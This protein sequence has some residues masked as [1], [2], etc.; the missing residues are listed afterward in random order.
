M[1]YDFEDKKQRTQYKNMLTII[2]S[3]SKL[4]SDNDKPYLAYR[5]HENCF[6]KYFDAENL[7]RHDCSADAMKD[8]IGVGLKTWINSDIQKVAEFNKLKH[9][10]DG[11]P[12][13][14]LVAKV[15]EFRN[16]RITTTMNMFD[17]NK[18]IYHVVIRNNKSMQIGECDFEK[19]DI[20]NIKLLK[21]TSKKN[22]V[23]FT[24][25]KHT[26]NFN[27]SKSTLYMKFDDLDILDT[28]DVNILDDPYDFLLDSFNSSTKQPHVEFPTLY[29]SQNTELYVNEDSQSYNTDNS[30]KFP[31]I[32]KHRV[33]ALKLYSVKNDKPFVFEKSGLNIWNAGGRKRHPDEVYI[34]FN[35]PDRDRPE[36]KDFFPPREKSF[37]LMLPNKQIL[38]AKIC[39]EQGKAIMS[40]PNKALG[41]WLLRDVLNLPEKTI[42][43]YDL[44][45]Q[46]G[47]DT[48]LFEKIDDENYSIYFTDSRIYD[49]L[50]NQDTQE[51]QN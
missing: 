3:L 2:G 16:D 29:P 23:Y 21:N 17:L 40:D 13:D 19:I 26:Y 5:A 33:L 39:Q 43:T 44:L 7:A 22:T 37:N 12:D 51:A 35:K 27:K 15:A 9:L 28:F 20:P 48:V 31:T 50:Y 6:C 11:L 4:F 10:L 34:P 32:D 42:I 41:K 38:S 14:E 45:Q 25:G 1:F 47:F 8:G 30:T 24:D 18:M 36:N 46:K 49:S